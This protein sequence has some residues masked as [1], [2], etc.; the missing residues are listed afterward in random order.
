MGYPGITGH[1]TYPW[2]S[3]NKYI[4]SDYA[5][6][7][8]FNLI[9]GFK[10]DHN[11][12][13]TCYIPKHSQLDFP[14]PSRA[15]SAADQHDEESM[16]A[17]L[18]RRRWSKPWTNCCSWWRSK[19]RRALST[20]PPYFHTCPKPA[21]G[22]ASSMCVAEAMEAGVLPALDEDLANMFTPLD[23]SLYRHK[24]TN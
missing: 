11:C 16:D 4:C 5:E 20:W 9:W 19:R 17:S 7:S 21:Q 13:T 15:Q 24:V 14:D 22:S 10:F 23:L 2:I 8:Q 12:D 1:M 3:Q 18:T 6:I